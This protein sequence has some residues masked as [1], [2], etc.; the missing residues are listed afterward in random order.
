MWYHPGAFAL[1]WRDVVAAWIICFTIAAALFGCGALESEG[2]AESLSAAMRSII[3]AAPKRNPPCRLG[4]PPV[5]PSLRIGV[6]RNA[7]VQV[8]HG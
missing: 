7:S 1:G 8:P 3:G 2:E 4:A 6:A 5:A